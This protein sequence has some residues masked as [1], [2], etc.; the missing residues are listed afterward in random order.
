MIFNGEIRVLVNI[1]KG[2]MEQ[3]ANACNFY[4]QKTVWL[5]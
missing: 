4:G 2:V 3:A 5:M 1:C